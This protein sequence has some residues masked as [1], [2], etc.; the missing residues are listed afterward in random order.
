MK[1]KQLAYILIKIFGLTIFVSGVMNIAG[2]IL[3]LIQV[4][5]AGGYMTLTGALMT[6]THGIISLAIGF[7][8]IAKSRHIADYLFKDDDE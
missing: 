2:G 6:P 7:I 8:L 1:T 5:S 3:N 4:R